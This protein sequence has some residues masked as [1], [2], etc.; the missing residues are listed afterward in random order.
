M[1]DSESGRASLSEVRGHPASGSTPKPSGRE[2]RKYLRFRIDE[3]SAGP[4]VKGFLT[5]LGFGRA[6][7]ARAAINLSEGGVMLL[8]R[9]PLPAGMKVRIRLE[10]EGCSDFVETTGEVRWC[11]RAARNIQESQAGIQFTGLSPADLNKI[12]EMRERLKAAEGRK[13]APATPG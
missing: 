2:V 8:V 13:E 7:K 3:A 1:A 5:S 9:E 6:N 10:M 12:A 4:P 11:D